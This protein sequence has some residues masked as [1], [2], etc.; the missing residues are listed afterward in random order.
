MTNPA[1]SPSNPPSEPVRRLLVEDADAIVTCDTVTG[2]PVVT[3][4][5]DRKA[6]AEKRGVDESSL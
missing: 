5:P 2:C 6:E 4:V 3:K 1:N